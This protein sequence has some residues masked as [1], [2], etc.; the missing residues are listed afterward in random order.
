MTD[1]R[2]LLERA[3]GP[4]DPIPDRAL[5]LTT[6]RAT[7]RQRRRRAGAAVVGLAASLLALGL[8]VWAF[9]GRDGTRPAGAQRGTFVFIGGDTMA[10]ENRLYAMNADGSDLRAIPTDDLFLMAS[11][12]S[13]DGERIALMAS[14]PWPKGDMPRPQLFLM[15]ADGSDLVEVPACPDA[16]CQGTIQVS[17]SPDGRSLSFPGN[18]TGI[19]VLD[20]Q[21][22]T[23]RRLTGGSQDVGAVFSSDGRRIAFARTEPSVDPEPNAQIWVMDA[24]GAGA[25]QLTDAALA[26]EAT[27]PA[28]SPDGTRIAYTEGGEPGGTAGIA[29][30]NVDGSAARQLTACTFG[31]CE[32]FPTN[33]V[34]SPDGSAIAVLWQ[35]ARL[36]GTAIALV[37]PE[38]G[39]LRIVRE[40]PFTASSLTWHVGAANT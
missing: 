14:E 24:D 10:A 22:G 9:A 26:H 2:S 16:G 19:Y 32:R 30:V 17:W 39:D 21:T 13:P 38:S 15:D 12:P 3:I 1:L 11:A 6:R 25:H 35:E 27:Q 34:W 28:W 31:S 8:V 7:Q 40:L 36:T 5:D 18:G 37:D 23:S 4:F 33:P 20:V 29:V